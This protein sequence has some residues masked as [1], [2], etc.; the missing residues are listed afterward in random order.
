MISD[1]SYWIKLTYNRSC[2]SF[3]VFGHFSKV[4]LSTDPAVGVFGVFGVSGVFGV[5]GVFENKLNIHKI[6]HVDDN[7]LI[8]LRSLKKNLA[9]NSRNG[10]PVRIPG[11]VNSELSALTECLLTVYLNINF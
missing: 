1:K 3:F 6:L 11:R 5:F 9:I 8:K 10:I 4:K 7:Q 2:K